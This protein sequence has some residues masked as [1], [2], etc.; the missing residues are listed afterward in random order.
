MQYNILKTPDIEELA[1]IIN[2]YI[3]VHDID[4]YIEPNITDTNLIQLINC[5]N[6]KAYND[7]K[8]IFSLLR[9]I[10]L[11]PDKSELPSEISREQYIDCRTHYIL[12]DNYYEDYITGAIGLWTNTSGKLFKRQSDCYSDMKKLYNL[13]SDINIEQKSLKNLS[14]VNSII[15]INELIKTIDKEDI[16]RLSKN[17][18][19]I[20]RTNKEDIKAEQLLPNIYIFEK[21]TEKQ[22]KL[23]QYNF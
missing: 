16:Q 7:N 22:S 2:S 21:N 14:P 18:I 3:V 4:T 8:Y 11:H 23:E 1:S 12:G 19:V 20:I 17:N 5:S 15:Y 13:A 9:Y 6:R 10:Q